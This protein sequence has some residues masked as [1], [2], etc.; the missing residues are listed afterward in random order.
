MRLNIKDRISNLGIRGDSMENKHIK[1]K[2]L[3]SGLGNKGG[4]SSV[5]KCI[6][7]NPYLKY[8]FT[9][10][11]HSLSRKSDV[12]K[13]ATFNIK[14]FY[15]FFKHYF[16]WLYLIYREK[17]S[18]AH[19]PITS[20]LNCYKSLIFLLTAR[21][22]GVKTV[23]HLHGGGMADFWNSLFPILKKL[24]RYLFSK[25]DALVVLSESWAEFALRDIAICEEKIYIIP[26]SLDVTW[27]SRLLSLKYSD[28]A[29]ITNILF[30]G[31]IGRKKGVHVLL[32]ALSLLKD[33]YDVRLI[34][35]GNEMEKGEMSEVE[36]LI[37]TLEL[38]NSVEYVG[39]A[40]DDAKLELFKKSMIFVLPSYY[41]GFPVS[42]IEAMAA[43]RAIISTPVGAIK[44]FLKD[45]ESALFVKVGDYVDLASKI[46]TLLKNKELALNLGN[47][48]RQIYQAKLSNRV[49]AR[50]L[51][52]V[53]LSVLRS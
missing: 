7:D 41:E 47:K 16:K 22:L 8:R 18:I 25:L 23:G 10:V 11:L 24:L 29:N 53:Y 19:Y 21:I 17:P 52:K 49:F 3:I 36:R 46:E 40:V 4:V 9:F 39:Y 51:E 44:D 28:A 38:S 33:K 35:A 5:V 15:Y 42:L 32:K 45:G 1:P 27:S 50:N 6:V 14:N 30:L 37:D 12:A 13:H 20:Y 26:N 48:A 31:S 43:G 34:L 2:V